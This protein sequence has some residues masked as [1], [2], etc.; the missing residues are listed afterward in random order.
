MKETYMKIS[1][2]HPTIVTLP[3]DWFPE[4]ALFSPTPIEEKKQNQYKQ[5]NKNFEVLKV[6]FFMCY[7]YLISNQHNSGT[8][9]PPSVSV[10]FLA[11]SF[12][13]QHKIDI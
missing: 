9:L 3:V 13:A 1:N 8:G 4:S 2:S 5:T 10:S 11:Y 12:C 7:H 6:I